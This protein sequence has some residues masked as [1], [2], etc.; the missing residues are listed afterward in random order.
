MKPRSFTY[1]R[2]ADLDE[3]VAALARLRDDARILAGGQSLV[4]M[5]NFRLVEAKALIDISDLA[6]LAYLREQDEAIEVGA[7]ATQAQFMA[8]PSLK[9]LAPLLSAA[10]P[11]VGHFQT[12]SRG[13]VCGSIAHSDPSSELPLC[14]AALGGSVV[15][16]SS[17]G[18]RVLAAEEFQTGMLTTAR[19]PDEVIA[20]VRFPKRRPAT[21]YAFTEMTQRHGDFAI[22]ALAAVV[23]ADAVRLGVGGVA[24][25]PAVR[26][27]SR[28][29][30][31]EIDDALN[32]LAW[33]LGGTDDAHAT[34]AYRRELV[35]RL[36]RRVI[37]EAANA[38]AR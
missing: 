22:C 16:R 13:T 1:I 20:A 11:H 30:E 23:S 36:G 9:A 12:R 6:A 18:T 8:W 32:D 25:K 19:R 24:D 14:L 26:T 35:R 38:R 4:P 7:A 33:E 27:W 34:A 17:S 3:T 5:M 28:L 10:M 37:A 2:P 15:L 21:G 31:G 29:E